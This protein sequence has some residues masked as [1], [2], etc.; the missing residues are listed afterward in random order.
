M[1]SMTITVDGV[2]YNIACSTTRRAVIRSSEVSGMLLD[3]TYYNDVVATYLEYTVKMAV[4]RG[5]ETEYAAL[6]EVLTNP[7][8]QHTFILP[9]NQTTTSVTGRVEVVQDQYVGTKNGVKLWRSISF[10][11][12]SNT[13]IKEPGA[14]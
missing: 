8:G 10:K 2:T 13:P 14:T 1:A 6:Y 7:V 3:K 4:P 5:S 9:Y 11:V 12:I